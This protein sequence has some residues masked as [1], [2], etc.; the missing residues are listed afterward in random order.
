MC[1]LNRT[2]ACKNSKPAGP[3]IKR[4]HFDWAPLGIGCRFVRPTALAAHSPNHSQAHTTHPS[5]PWRLLYSKLS[6]CRPNLPL[7]KITWILKSSPK[8][9][10]TSGCVNFLFLHMHECHSFA[11]R[12]ILPFRRVPR[13]LA[14]FVCVH[15]HVALIFRL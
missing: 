5:L 12:R 7:M 8:T 2:V 3:D 6:Q 1:T 4:L 11:G 15:D 9:C 14:F 10:F 13:R